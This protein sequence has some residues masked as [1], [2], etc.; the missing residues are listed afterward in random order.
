VFKNIPHKDVF[1]KFSVILPLI[2]R[3]RLLKKK[4]LLP[5][6]K[7]APVPVEAPGE[8]KVTQRKGSRMNLAGRAL[9]AGAR[10]PQRMLL[11]AAM[12]RVHQVGGAMIL[13]AR[14]AR[15]HLR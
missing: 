11:V 14:R 2:N 10:L 8:M 3:R 7:K 1:Q 6:A 5:A 4:N 9:I 13:P 15:S 12:S